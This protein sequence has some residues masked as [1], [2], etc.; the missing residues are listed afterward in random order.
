[1]TLGELYDKLEAIRKASETV[2]IDMRRLENASFNGSR[3]ETVAQC[4]KA[5]EH[6]AEWLKILR[7][8]TIGESNG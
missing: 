5:L 2:D 6:S 1:M 4:A 7:A 3:K 8:E